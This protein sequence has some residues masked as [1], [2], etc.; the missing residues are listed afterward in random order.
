METRANST[1]PGRCGVHLRVPEPRTGGLE[2]V[3][4]LG[5]A[6]DARGAANSP[7]TAEKRTRRYQSSW[8]CT[9]AKGARGVPNFLGNCSKN[10]KKDLKVLELTLALKVEV[11]VEN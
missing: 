1:G 2:P 9:R 8:I 7:E 10:R 6:K 11:T 5:R 3:E 4:V